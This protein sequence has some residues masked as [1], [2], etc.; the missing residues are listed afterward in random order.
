MQSSL[1]SKSLPVQR[2]LPHGKIRWVKVSKMFWLYLLKVVS[3]FFSISDWFKR[4]T[5]DEMWRSSPNIPIVNNQFLCYTDD[6]LSQFWTLHKVHRREGQQLV[7]SPKQIVSQNMKWNNK[8][9]C[10]QFINLL[11][12]MSVYHCIQ[13]LQHGLLALHKG[14]HHWRQIT[15]LN[16]SKQWIKASSCEF[17]SSSLL[18]KFDASWTSS[19]CST[20]VIVLRGRFPEILIAKPRWKDIKGC[21]WSIK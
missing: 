16:K 15:H 20:V 2:F 13:T 3:F 12:W 5:I 19:L 14:F 9:Y 7:L 17:G 21:D 18:I 1:V 8:S 6:Q 4:K 11:L 10:K